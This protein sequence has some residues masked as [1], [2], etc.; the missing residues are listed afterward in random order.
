M[1]RIPTN[2]SSKSHNAFTF[3]F[4]L[5]RSRIVFVIVMFAAVLAVVWPG[6][7][8]FSAPKPF[9]FGFP[10]SFAWTIFWVIVSFA[11]M[12]MLYLSDLNHEDE[13]P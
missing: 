8:I 12:T 10:L 9:I 1:A 3:T 5:R 2:S 6:H 4:T 13:E 7:A 11:A